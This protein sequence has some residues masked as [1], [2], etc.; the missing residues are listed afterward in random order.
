MVEDRMSTGDVMEPSPKRPR[1]TS[2][3]QIQS[4][5][6]RPG[7]VKINVQGAFI[8]DEE[9]KTQSNGLLGVECQNDTNDIRLPNHTEVVSHVAVDVSAFP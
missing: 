8:V 2:T 6:Q 4:T 5:I 7:A 3:A 9:E 1:V